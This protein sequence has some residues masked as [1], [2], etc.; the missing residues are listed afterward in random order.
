MSEAKDI[1][2]SGDYSKHQQMQLE[3][4]LKN[5]QQPELNEQERFLPENG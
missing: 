4:N 1:L 5:Q 2:A 3:Y